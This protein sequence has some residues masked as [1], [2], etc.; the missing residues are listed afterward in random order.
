MVS[1]MLIIRKALFYIFLLFYIILCPLIILY[2]FGYI[3]KPSMEEAV[4]KTGLIYISTAPPGAN[5]DIDDKT[6]HER[7]P[8]TLQELLPKDYDISITL[9]GYKTWQQTVPVKANTATVL[10]S[11][12]MIPENW[13]YDRVIM[14]GF[15]QMTPL[16]G[17]DY[18]FLNITENLGDYILYNIEK[19]KSYRVA[20]KS[21]DIKAGIVKEIYT[22]YKSTA[23]VIEI[24]MAGDVRYLHGDIKNDKVVLTDISKLL[25]KKPF[26]ILWDPNQADILFAFYGEYADMLEVEKDALYPKHIESI[27]GMGV[28]D[29]RIYTIKKDYTLVR[30]RYDKEGIEILLDDK[31]LGEKLFKGA[32]YFR[33]TPLR[34]DTIAF[35]SDKGALLSNHLPYNFIPAGLKG[36]DLSPDETMLLLWTRNYIATIDFSKEETVSTTFEKGSQLKVLFK[37][38]KNINNAFFVHELSHILFCDKNQVYL[39]GIY[40]NAREDAYFVT[41]IK[42]NTNVYFDKDN[43][44]LYYIEPKSSNLCSVNI[45]PETASVFTPFSSEKAGK[46]KEETSTDTGKYSKDI[47]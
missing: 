5:V 17:T 8:F 26:F 24:S 11:I 25:V 32:G 34:S 41:E 13:Q 33:I 9:D 6:Y 40:R 44:I 20:D 43:S 31:A 16:R 1:N 10:D 38:G 7:T 47:E 30:F 19:N 28:L 3:F 29:R 36:H 14:E 2:A 21:D 15:K 27:I 42:N 18:I 23:F 35:T 37:N 39:K 4:T 45:L 22:T 46:Y 12:I